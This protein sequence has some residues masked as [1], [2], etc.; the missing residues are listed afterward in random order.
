MVALEAPAD[1][2]EDTAES[3]AAPAP[4][5]TQPPAPKVPFYKREISFGGSRS[6]AASTATSAGAARRQKALVGVKIGASG[7]SAARV[8]Q[9]GGRA[10]LLELVREPLTRGVVVAGEVRDVPA[11]ATALA[12]MFALHRLPKK[13][14]RLG[15]SNNRIG[16][17]IIEVSGV[18]EPRQLENAI[19]FRAQE[20]LPI[21]LEDAVLDYQQLSESVNA[22]GELV[23]RVLLVVAYRD[24]IDR[25]VIAFKEAG[26]RLVGIDLE[27][28]GLLRALTP[29]AIGVRSDAAHVVVSIGHERSTFA[30]S[31]G[32][33]CEF[34][35][36][37]EWGGSTLDVAI[38]RQ[39]NLAPSEA[40]P[41]KHA[42][43][44][45]GSE[46]V[47]PPNVTQEQVNLAADIVRR[48][49]QTFAR[50]LVSSLQYYQNQ[51]NSL[52][53]GDI[54]I[55]GGTSLLPG[56]AGELQRLIG[57][58]VRVGDPFERVRVARGVVAGRTSARSRPQSDWQSRSRG[59]PMRAINLLPKDAERARRTTPDP[60]L[61]TG[62]IGVAVVILALGWMFLSASRTVQ[63]KQ[64][65]RDDLASKL[66]EIN[67]LNPPP[68]FL[69]IQTAM[70]PLQ[71][72]RVSAATSAL[73][74]RIP[75][76]DIL[77]QIAQALP[78]GVKLTTL[79]A[80]SPISP[81]PTFVRRLRLEPQTTFSSAAGP[82][83][84]SRSRC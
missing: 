37:L 33:V 47:L 76:D 28:F 77:G 9:N 63:D 53:I 32:N 29:G 75:W 71:A 82:M 55:T 11:L 14:V 78:S 19:R 40:E 72:P 30:V 12:N 24:L 22:D 74:F 7:I 17:R 26:V 62:I 25:Y 8:V 42:I 48:Q 45:D 70:A 41:V 51:S 73:S 57:V 56:L 23:R 35:R 66:A 39:L 1:V 43:A 36:V 31:D 68:K 5:P 64:G 2:S 38:A 27:A 81:N 4:A 6:S 34:T 20:V 52:G 16:V 59:R 60:A 69:A 84:R 21:A 18:M 54:V 67:R 10:E 46:L 44:L 49:L 65:Q 3:V 61:L 50:E 58:S 13:A 15:I 83:R 79:N 80:T